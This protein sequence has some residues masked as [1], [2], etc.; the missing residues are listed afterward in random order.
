M[1]SRIPFLSL[2]VAIHTTLAAQTPCSNYPMVG[3]ATVNADGIATTTGGEG[4]TS[5]TITNITDLHEWAKGRE[6]NT[7][8]QVLY[9]SGKIE[10][11]DASL[12]LVTIKNG[13]NIS[14]IGTNGGE[15]KGVGL[16]IRDYNNV[17][18][19]N[20]KIHEV[21]YPN[22]GLTLDN[23]NHAWVDHNE[24]YSLN[25]SGIT[26]DTY[27]GLFDIK[28][29]ARYITVS[30][31]VFHDHKKVLLIGH[32]DNTGAQA[33][34]SQIKVTIHHNYFYNN[35]GRNPSLRFGTVHLYNNYFKILYDYGIAVRQGAH[36][37]IENNVYQDVVTPI[38]TD[39]FDGPAGY[40]CE[41]GNIFDHVGASSITQEGCEW[42]TGTN[43]P[44]KYTL[45]KAED[46]P[47]LLI[48]D[49]GL[50]QNP[51]NPQ[52]TLPLNIVVTGLEASELYS[53]SVVLSPNPASSFQQLTLVVQEPAWVQIVLLDQMGTAIKTIAQQKMASGERTLLVDIQD[54]A[55]GMYVYE[56]AVGQHK[57]HLR[58]IINH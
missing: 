26:V 31:N 4:G 33:E 44:Y 10:T 14:I 38:A 17:I 39:K 1:H 15:L 49:A 3:F 8:P 7:S 2:L 47:A 32:T 28:K 6:K 19:R 57:K 56:I 43:L 30:W 12:S 24:F 54:V 5:A 23:V 48:K 35:D 29:G 20:L 13:A 22:D 21:L 55:P 46:V 40:A 41:K 27:D 50:C 16:N 45:D 53:S 52:P 34:D 9:I 18:V 25:K 58:T 42:W 37:L 36:A 11:T 51:S